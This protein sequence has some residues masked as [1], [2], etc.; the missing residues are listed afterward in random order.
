[1]YQNIQPIYIIVEEKYINNEYITKYIPKY[2]SSF[3]NSNIIGNIY[4]GINDNGIIEGIP[5]CGELNKN[6]IIEV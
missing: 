2:I 3:S 5:F 1:M 6:T 4:I